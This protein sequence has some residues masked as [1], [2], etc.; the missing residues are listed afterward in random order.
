MA[1]LGANKIALVNGRR[2]RVVITE[3]PTTPQTIDVTRAFSLVLRFGE[4]EDSNHGFQGLGY[5]LKRDRLY[6]AKE[7][8]PK[9]LY[10]ISAVSYT[11]LTLPTIYSV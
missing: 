1:W 5:D 4:D 9:G 10:R 7:H 6:I 2:N 11:H 3:I 8:S